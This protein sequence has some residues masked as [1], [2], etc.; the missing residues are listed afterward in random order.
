[1]SRENFSAHEMRRG[2]HVLSASAYREWY[3]QVDANLGAIAGDEPETSEA[4]PVYVLNGTQHIWKHHIIT[5]MFGTHI[6]SKAAD[7]KILELKFN[8][9]AIMN[10]YPDNHEM[11]TSYILTCTLNLGDPDKCQ[12]LIA[13]ITEKDPEAMRQF[14]E[15]F[16]VQINEEEDLGVAISKMREKETSH[17]RVHSYQLFDCPDQFD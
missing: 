5:K 14:Q 12:K 9:N 10:R 11:V 1:M 6:V 17:R 3:E 15:E 13:K 2:K 4:G 16:A 7:D 8:R